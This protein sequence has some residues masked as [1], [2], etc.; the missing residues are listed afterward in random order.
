MRVLT[1][2][3]TTI[4]PQLSSFHAIQHHGWDIGVLTVSGT[5]FKAAS[6]L[7]VRR[8]VYADFPRLAPTPPRFDEKRDAVRCRGITT[9]YAGRA[10]AAKGII[11]LDLLPSRRALR[12]NFHRKDCLKGNTEETMLLR[13]VRERKANDGRGQI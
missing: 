6:S 5:W 13:R 4:I 8:R 2:S 10:L 7:R 9:G 12:S 1:L 11:V 3:H